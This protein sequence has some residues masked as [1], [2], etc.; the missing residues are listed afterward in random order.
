MFKVVLKDE[1][2]LG[3]GSHKK[4]FLH[5]NNTNQCIKIPYTTAGEKD[6]LR[7]LAYIKVMHKK[8]K[9]Y[10]ILPEY[11]GAIETNLGTGHVYELITDFD[12]SKSKTLEDF[13]KDDNLL[14]ENFEMIVQL[15]KDL[16]YTLV[17]NQIITMG[18]WP[19]NIILQYGG[20]TNSTGY[21]LRII[22]DMGSAALIPL[23]YYLG[24]IAKIRINKRW[25][26]FINTLRKFYAS[27]MVN[28]LADR[29]NI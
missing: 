13:L 5:P 22:N 24:F 28:R 12:G 23:E 20:G 16:K 4:C 2:F 17:D 6:L 7:E 14:E 26:R 29:I 18:I 9:D 11:F 21:R 27:P 25:S 15:L 10:S 19:E 1:H 3:K 8:K